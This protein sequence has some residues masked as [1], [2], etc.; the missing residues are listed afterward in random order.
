MD[1]LQTQNLTRRLGELVA[2]DEASI[3]VEESEVY[4]GLD[5]DQKAGRAGFSAGTIA[6]HSTSI[7]QPGRQTGATTT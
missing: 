7:S 4:G 5:N 2:V 1:I 6:W 3:S